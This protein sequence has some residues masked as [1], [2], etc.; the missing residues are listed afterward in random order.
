M[1]VIIERKLG[2][3]DVLTSPAMP[4]SLLK[5][6]GGDYYKGSRIQPIEFIS[7]NNMSFMQGSVIKYIH[8]YKNKNGVE[9]LKKAKH[10]IELMIELE[11]LNG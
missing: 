11:Y 1:A 10:Y 5:Q 9:D 8:R 4:A 7:A 3:P 2:D 6:E